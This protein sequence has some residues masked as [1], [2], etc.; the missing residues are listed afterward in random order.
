MICTHAIKSVVR[1]RAG[2]ARARRELSDERVNVV[3]EPQDMCRALSL[4][5]VSRAAAGREEFPSS[6]WSNAR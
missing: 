4:S 6:A 1:P 5:M 2:R 3:A